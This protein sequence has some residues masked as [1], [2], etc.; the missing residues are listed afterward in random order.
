[1]LFKEKYTL[2]NCGAVDQLP[3]NK[4][5]GTLLVGEKSLFNWEDDFSQ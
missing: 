1:M 5:D 4:V 3:D 2:M